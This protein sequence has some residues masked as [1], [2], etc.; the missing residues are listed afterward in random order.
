MEHKAKSH[1]DLFVWQKAIDLAE[2]VYAVTERFPQREMYGLVSQMRRAVVSIS[3][4]IAE[5]RNRGTRKDYAHFLQIAYGSC[6]ELE[7]QLIIAQRL[8]FCSEPD[9]ETATL[10][11]TEVAK[12]LHVMIQKLN[13]AARS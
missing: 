12:M 7:T 3:S 13:G 10:Q 6:A 5:G 2:C 4:N 9:L 1:K 11:L 8:R